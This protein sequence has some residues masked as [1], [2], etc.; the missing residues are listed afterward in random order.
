MEREIMMALGHVDHAHKHMAGRLLEGIV[1]RG[2][3]PV[4]R[5]L[6]H[7]DGC[8]Q[9][10]IAENCHVKAASVSSVLDNMEQCGY[11][12]RQALEGD[13]RAQRVYLTE[14]GRSK[15]EMVKGV[16]RRLEEQCLAGIGDDELAAFRGTLEK[17]I[18][19]MRKMDGEKEGERADD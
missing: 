1:S 14:E 9:R 11:I 16:F 17:I 4:M 5:Y 2:Q 18:A 6:E 8:I 12:S 15:C 3:P 7:H 13:R 10:D 19:N